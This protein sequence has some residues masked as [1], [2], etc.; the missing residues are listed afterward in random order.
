MALLLPQRSAWAEAYQCVSFEYPPLITQRWGSAAPTGFAVELVQRM[1]RQLGAS[2]TVQ[3]Y[4]WERDGQGAA[5]RSRLHLYHL[6][7]PGSRTVPRL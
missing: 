5:G 7:L 6:P 3:L 2:V 1:F 4:P